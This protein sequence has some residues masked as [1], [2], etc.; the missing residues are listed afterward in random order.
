M[1]KLERKRRRKLT[2]KKKGKKYI[3]AEKTKVRRRKKGHIR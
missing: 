3:K 2:S 1:G